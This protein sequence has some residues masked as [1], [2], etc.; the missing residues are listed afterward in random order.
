MQALFFYVKHFISPF[1]FG[2]DLTPPNY[3]LGNLELRRGELK[4]VPGAVLYGFIPYIDDS[5]P[6][7]INYVNYR[8]EGYSKE[9]LSNADT[10]LAQQELTPETVSKLF[11]ILV[12]Q[13][14]GTDAGKTNP[15][16]PKTP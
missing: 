11:P 14:L 4:K 13:Q 3:V 2:V 9:D 1:D 7:K 16:P 8:I 15:C 6:E 5:N 12:K 10:T